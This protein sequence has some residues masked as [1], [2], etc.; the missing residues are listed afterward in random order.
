VSQLFAES[1]GLVYAVAR[2]FAHVAPVEDLA[3]E[4]Q[5]GLLRAIELFDPKKGSWGTYAYGWVKAKILQYVKK[6]PAVR[7]DLSGRNGFHVIPVVSLDAP[8]FDDSEQTLLDTLESRELAA[9]EQLEQQDVRRQVRDVLARVKFT[10][11]AGAIVEQRLL[12]ERPATLDVLGHQFGVSKERVRQVE[13]RVRAKL[14][15]FLAPVH[16]EAADV[17]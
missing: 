17:L 4:G 9:D 11:L 7:G 14:Q 10:G 6:H 2:K 8:R 5:L 16:A 13:L 3:Q 12:H 1:Q 15:R